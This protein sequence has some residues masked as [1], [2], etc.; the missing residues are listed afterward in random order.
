MKGRGKGADIFLDLIMQYTDNKGDTLSSAAPVTGAKKAT[1]TTTTSND[2]DSYTPIPNETI[3]AHACLA[4]SKLVAVGDWGQT[5]PPA[6]AAAN[7]S[8]TAD[9][10][11]VDSSAAAAAPPIDLVLTE[12]SEQEYSVLLHIIMRL[13]EKHELHVPR[14]EKLQIRHRATALHHHLLHHHHHLHL[15][16]LIQPQNYRIYLIV[17]LFLLLVSIYKVLPFYIFVLN[18]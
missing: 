16:M 18:H 1:A 17:L 14:R 2:P 9:D 7:E 11:S 15:L 12:E 13:I 3:V 8:K 10:S 6:T 4:L 5:L